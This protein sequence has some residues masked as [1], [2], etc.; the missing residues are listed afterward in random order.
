[1][2]FGLNRWDNDKYLLFIDSVDLKNEIYEL[3]CKHLPLLPKFLYLVLTARP[4]RQSDLL[5]VF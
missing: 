4:K 2:E 1:M 5:L 3:I